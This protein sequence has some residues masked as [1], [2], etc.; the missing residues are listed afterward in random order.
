MAGVVKV[1]NWQKER[2]VTRSLSITRPANTTQYAV[3]DVLANATVNDLV[4]TNVAGTDYSGT[5]L[6]M[7]AISDA[8]PATTLQGEV[9]LFDKPVAQ[10]ADNAAF[11]LSDAHATTLVSVIPFTLLAQ[12]SNSLAVISGINVGYNCITQDL[13]ALIKVKNAYTPVSGEIVTF[14]FKIKQMTG[15]A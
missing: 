13:Y 14:R 7:V 10:V 9:W 11:A 5:I 15:G 6:D 8:V 12:A 2:V 3:D 1:N 4:L